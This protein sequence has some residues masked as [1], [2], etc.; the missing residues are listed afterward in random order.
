MGWYDDLIRERKKKNQDIFEA[1]S[2]KISSSVFGGGLQE[3]D[4]LLTALKQIFKY[5]R[6]D[7]TDIPSRFNDV[8]N[9][10]DPILMKHDLLT[11][12]IH[13][14]EASMRHNQEP[15]LAYTKESKTPVAFLPMGDYAYYLIHPETGKKCMITP[16]ILEDFDVDAT[17]FY[18]PLPQKKL[19]LDDYA[20][21]VRRNVRVR[22]LVLVLVLIVLVTGVG[23]TIPFLTRI[24]IGD[25]I[26]NLDY[27]LFLTIA[28]SLSGAA[29]TLLLIKT[30]QGIVNARVALRVENSVHSAMMMRLLSL[31]ASFFKKYNTGEL[32][33]RLNMVSAISNLMVTGIFIGGLTSILGM[34]YI[35]A[36]AGFSVAL[37][38]PSLLV[39]LANLIF[40]IVVSFIERRVIRKRTRLNA[41]E[42]G[43]SYALISGIQKIR[44]TGSEKRA[45][46]KWTDAYIPAARVQYNP[47]WVVKLSPVI[48]ALISAA[49]GVLIYYLVALNNVDSGTYVAFF[50]AY[51]SLS[52]SLLALSTIINNCVRIR[53][54]LEMVVPLLEE[55]PESNGDKVMV[56]ELSGAIRL[57]HVSFQYN[58]KTP[59][60]LN[61]LSIDIKPGEYVAIVGKTGC[62]KSTIVRLLLGF[63]KPNIGK[64]YFDDYDIADVDLPSLRRKIGSVTQNGSLFHADIFHNITIS[65][66]ELGEPEAWEAAR[67]AN[68][69]EDIRKMPMGMNTVISEGQGSISGGQKQRLMIARAIVHKPRIIIFDE[70]TSALD[71]Q[72]QKE[73]TESIGKLN[74]TRVII[75]HRLSTIKQCDRILFLEGGKIVEEGTYDELIERNGRFKELVERQRIEE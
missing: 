36:I 38:L 34:S 43:V 66:P 29:I 8:A 64:V 25:V 74:C 65:A 63:E 19:T 70:A 58:D 10:L 59:L 62:G 31:P 52:A 2:K 4:P 61:D 67:I 20:G 11:R 5:Y 6:L 55:E 21:Y 28:L 42:S 56:E 15:I 9:E 30:T 12:K 35:V 48:S 13:L 51:A 60:V 57:D 32:N 7:P 24:L 33:M 49:G 27:N 41:R 68:I 72:C 50:S 71:N 3:D 47:P 54:M 44:I 1:S 73:I 69:D 45:Y 40:V 26:D 16:Q 37:V 22:D 18:H 14:E 46:A 17:T 53:P 39:V 75:A 23:L